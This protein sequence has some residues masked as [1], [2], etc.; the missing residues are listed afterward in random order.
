VPVAKFDNN[1]VHLKVTGLTFKHLYFEHLIM[2][3]F[4]KA[5]KM[6]G[7]KS[8]SKKIRSMSSG[9]ADIYYQFE[10]KD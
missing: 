10:L 7:K 4:Q 3:F 2:G 9:D 6:F 1:I 8:V 5:L